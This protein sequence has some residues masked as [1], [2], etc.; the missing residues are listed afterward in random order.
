MLCHP[1]G[2]SR[3]APV[4]RVNGPVPWAWRR[5]R[6][7]AATGRRWRPGPVA[8]SP[9]ASARLRGRAAGPPFPKW[10]R[11]SAQSA[12]A[13]AAGLG[14]E[15]RATALCDAVVSFAAR[16]LLGLGWHRVKTSSE[17]H[18]AARWPQPKEGRLPNRPN[19]ISRRF[20][21]GWATAAPGGTMKIVANAIEVD[22]YQHTVDQ[23]S[24]AF[25]TRRSRRP[26]SKR[27]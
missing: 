4:S 8:P 3:R 27:G 15:P 2:R 11:R 20:F 19:T 16:G 22:R 25:E 24:S 9:A 26:R 6:R 12:R 1:P 13:G 10:H 14:H 18:S 21:G 5:S 17:C 7:L 23:L